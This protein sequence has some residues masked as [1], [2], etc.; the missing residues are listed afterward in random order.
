MYKKYLKAWGLEKNLKTRESIAMLRI[1]ERRRL[2]NKETHFFRHGQL[3]EPGKLRRFA[4]RHKLIGDAAAAQ[5]LA[6]QEGTCPFTPCNWAKRLTFRS[7]DSA[8]HHVY[9]TGTRRIQ[10]L[11]TASTPTLRHRRRTGGHGPG[12]YAGLA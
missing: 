6:D 12:R 5:L 2:A 4:K 1:A 9:N 8:R 7:E 11:S 3:V 10:K